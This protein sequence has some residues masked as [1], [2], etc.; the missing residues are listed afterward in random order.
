[1]SFGSTHRSVT[2]T[3]T[4]CG[5]QCVGLR[6]SAKSAL[7]AEKKHTAIFCT[8]THAHTHTHTRTSYTVCSDIVSFVKGDFMQGFCHLKIKIFGKSS[9]FLKRACYLRRT[10]ALLSKRR[11]LEVCK[12]AH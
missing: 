7:V 3:V 11:L 2:N 12:S 4:A 5:F 9:F 10:T 6:Y 8:L 1:M